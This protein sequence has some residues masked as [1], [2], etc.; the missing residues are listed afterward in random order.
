[1]KTWSSIKLTGPRRPRSAT[2]A[3]GSAMALFFV[4]T[5]LSPNVIALIEPNGAVLPVVANFL[6]TAATS[7]SERLGGGE[8]EAWVVLADSSSEI[9]TKEPQDFAWPIV[10]IGA[11]VVIEKNFTGA[12]VKVAV[13]DT[14]IDYRHPALSH[15]YRGGYD[16]VNNDTDPYDDNGH[17][18]FVSGL[19]AGVINGTKGTLGAAPDVEIYAIKVMGADGRGQLANIVRGVRWAIEN[20]VDIICMSM[21]L[22]RDYPELREA[23]DE[24][25]SNGIL[26]VSAA[27]N[28]GGRVT[29]PARYDSVIA[30]GSVDAEAKLSKTSSTGPE[31]E[32]VAPGV[33]VLSAVP[34]GGFAV[35]NGTSYAAG[36]VAGALALLISS[37]PELDSQGIR[38]LLRKGTIDLGLPGKDDQYGY[39]LVNV[40]GAILSATPVVVAED[41]AS[42]EYVFV[43]NDSEIAA[44]M[45]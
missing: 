34:G 22:F 16:F 38:A 14:G 37:H 13:I 26:I 6:G 3:F 41:L 31:V 2:R 32:V 36:Y 10:M 29:Y 42:S 23:L 33:N 20:H 4:I 8:D 39:G 11:D 28:T 45:N 40:E 44:E 15:A 27:G 21:S 25:Y 30:V 7:Q 18:T 43:A 19:I 17:G 9:I 12:G 24:A 1:M 5:I 35:K